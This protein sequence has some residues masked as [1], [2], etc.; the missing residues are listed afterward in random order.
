MTN[1]E[2]LK[3]LGK[4]F[5]FGRDDP[6]VINLSMADNPVSFLIPFGQLPKAMLG[7]KTTA[8]ASKTTLITTTFFRELGASGSLGGRWFTPLGPASNWETFLGRWTPFFV[9]PWL[10][11]YNITIRKEDGR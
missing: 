11:Y 9:D 8:E 6:R 3:L 2:L 5:L 7:F 4:Q 10:A 1:P